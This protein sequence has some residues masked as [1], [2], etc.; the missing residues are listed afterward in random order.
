MAE[1]TKEKQ[2]PEQLI[3]AGEETQMRYGTRQE[4]VDEYVGLILT[5]EKAWPFNTRCV[6]FKDDDKY[7]LADGFHRV[8]AVRKAGRVTVHCDL[9]EGTLEDAQDYALAANKTH[10][11][12]RTTED[13]HRA[14]DCALRMDRWVGK[15]D[16]VIADLVGV[17]R[18]T[19]TKRRELKVS[20]G[21][22]PQLN[23]TEGKDG[24]KRKVKPKQER[25]PQP[26]PTIV[27]PTPP[28]EAVAP[29]EEYED[30]DPPPIE[31]PAP[32]TAGG[33]PLVIVTKAIKSMSADAVETVVG[34]IV[35]IHPSLRRKL[36]PQKTKGYDTDFE[37]FWDAFPPG[38][39]SK[40]MNAYKAWT[41]AI[42]SVDA[43]VIIDAAA[44]YAASDV[45]QGEYVSGPEPWLNGGCWDDDRT[46]WRDKQSKSPKTFEQTKIDNMISGTQQFIAEQR[47]K[48]NQKLIGG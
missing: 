43:L 20:T 24:K 48:K 12:R 25:E 37:T 26:R 17:S 5:S 27:K 28:P 41:K 10:G 23:S 9:Y 18:K 31:E 35:A 47:Q 38:R 1:E 42:K 32:N 29:A 44:E 6:V 22:I 40:K 33:N 11:L 21:E 36:G 46:A 19:V 14:I 2:L 13:K 16:G 7:Y 45:G 8:E 3:I 34:V 30:F 39:K 4:T 15:S